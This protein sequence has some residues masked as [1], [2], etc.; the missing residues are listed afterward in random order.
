MPHICNSCLL[1]TEAGEFLSFD[2]S[3]GYIMNFRLAGLQNERLFQNKIIQN[4]P[5]LYL[6][7]H[8]S[9]TLIIIHHHLNG[10]HV[11]Q[12]INI[13]DDDYSHCH[14]PTGEGSGRSARLKS[15]F[16]ERQTL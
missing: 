6:N 15:K 10:L 7:A 5:N 1:E 3:L 2:S 8:G 11:Q 12:L 16:N 9:I 14:H 4:D 13:Y